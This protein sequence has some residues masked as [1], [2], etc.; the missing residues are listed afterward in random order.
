MTWIIPQQ[1]NNNYYVLLSL[2]ILM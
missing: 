2:N 1:Y